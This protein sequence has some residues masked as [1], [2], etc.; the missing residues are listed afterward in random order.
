MLSQWSAASS[1][2]RPVDEMA[3]RFDRQ[4]SSRLLILPPLFDEAN[5]F[6]RQLVEIMRRLDR[7][8]IDAMLPDLP[9]Q[10][11]STAKLADQTLSGWRAAAAAAADQFAATHWL[12][13]R[14]ST[15]LVLDD[16]PGWQ[17]APVGGRQVLRGMLRAAALASRETGEPVDADAL[18]EQGLREGAT[19]AGFPLGPGMIGE[20]AGDSP[21]NERLVRIEHETLGGKPLW[22]R[23][24]PDEDPEQADALAAFVAMGIGAR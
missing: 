7:A 24:E 16:R 17:Y 23:A 10:N 9:G 4:R 21:A 14:A 8:G 13:I 15:I 22:L 18:R 12:T 1:S 6:R 19:L 20:L 2:G 3:V 11:E 5:K